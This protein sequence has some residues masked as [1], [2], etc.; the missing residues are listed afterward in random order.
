[1]VNIAPNI[2][3]SYSR[4]K[5]EKRLY[6]VGGSGGCVPMSVIIGIIGWLLLAN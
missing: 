3:P 5:G 2:M 6:C 1:M 4:K